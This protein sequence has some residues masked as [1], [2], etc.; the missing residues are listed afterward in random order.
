[1][2]FDNLETERLLL[3]KIASD[4]APQIQQKFPHW[5]IVKYLDSNAVPWPY[6]D[7]A[8]EYFVNNIAH[9]AI[10]S[11][12]AWIW[13]IRMKNNPDELIGVIGLYDNP[14]NNRG[15]W[16]SF[17][18]QGQGLMREACEKVTDY[19]FHILDQP[20]LRTQKASI[21]QSSKKISSE[22]GARIIKVEKKRYVSG[23][24]DN[25]TWEITREEWLNRNHPL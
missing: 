16:L 17:E 24:Y 18:Y 3:K 1:M 8:A 13:S 25:E 5:E 7:D 19:W 11:G 20:V 2:P 21:N 22:Q 14:N 23:T 12:K 9:P 6:P 15:F 4:D 10:Q